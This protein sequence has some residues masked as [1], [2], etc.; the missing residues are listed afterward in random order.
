MTVQVLLDS[1]VSGPL[2]EVL[3][4]DGLFAGQRGFATDFG[5]APYFMPLRWDGSAW[6]YEAEFLPGKTPS[7]HPCPGLTTISAVGMAAATTGTAAAANVADTS[8]YARLPRVDVVASDVAAIR[9]NVMRYWRGASTGTGGFFVRCRFGIRVTSPTI[10]APRAFCG[11]RSNTGTPT[12]VEPSTYNNLLGFGYDSADSTWSFMHKTGSGTVAKEALSG[13]SK[14]SVDT[15]YE[16]IIFCAPHESAVHY[17]LRNITASLEASGSVSSS[18]P[19]DTTTLSWLLVTSVAGASST[20]AAISF[21]GFF[22][23]TYD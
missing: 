1:T 18:I 19:S 5:K 2:A 14:P 10:T 15:A 12:D 21:M 23:R 11:L 13:W 4:R 20:S 6:D 16:A 8:A 22:G 3:A 17:V 9:D 7:A